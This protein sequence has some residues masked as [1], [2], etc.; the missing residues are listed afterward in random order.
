MLV[1]DDLRGERLE[2]ERSQRIARAA[3]LDRAGG[4]RFQQPGLGV[5]EMFHL[6]LAGS[7]PRDGIAYAIERTSTTRTTTCARGRRWCDSIRGAGRSR[8]DGPCGR[9]GRRVSAIG[10]IMALVA[11]GRLRARRGDPGATGA[12]DEALA[13]ATQTDTLQRLAPV[14]AARAEAAWLDGDRERRSS[15]RAPSTTSRSPI[16]TP[17][18]PASSP[19][20]RR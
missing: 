8:R 20:W 4:A 19:F 13:L 12:L 16:V 11:L 10:R 7:L 15:R 14:R 5:G 2:I 3:G 9:R 6:G 1:V 18:T 17:G